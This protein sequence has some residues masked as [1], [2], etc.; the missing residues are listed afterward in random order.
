M[1]LMPP[2]V[3]SGVVLMPVS[4]TAS[5]SSK[6]VCGFVLLMSCAVPRVRYD[7]I[8]KRLVEDSSSQHTL[9]ATAEVRGGAAAHS[10]RPSQAKLAASCPGVQ[11]A[12]C[13]GAGNGVGPSV[14]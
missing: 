4:T 12:F 2:S 9:Q 6:R 14:C 5:L 3:Y 11:V 10:E 8:H 13:D 1:Q 7:S